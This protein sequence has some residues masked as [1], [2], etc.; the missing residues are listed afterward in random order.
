MAA[1]H[2]AVAD[3]PIPATEILDTL[4]GGVVVV[5]AADLRVRFANAAAEDMVGLS[6][7]RL[8]DRPLTEVAEFGEQ[9]LASAAK[10]LADGAAFTARQV[11]LQS[12]A[13]SAPLSVDIT[14]TPWAAAPASKRGVLELVPVDRH[15]RIARE[16]GLRDQEV[17]NRRL[18]R[19]LAHEIRNPLAGLR[20]A[21]QL[22]A[23]AGDAAERGEYT[24]MIV[25]EA[26]RLRAL[27][28]RMG[29]PDRPPAFEPVNIHQLT[30]HLL[31]LLRGEAGAGIT[32]RTHY[33]PSLPEVAGDRDQLLQALLNLGRNALQAVGEA[34]AIHVRTSARRRFTIAGIQHRVVACIEVADDG[35]G[36][37]AELRESLFQPLV[38]GRAE[39][40]GLGLSLAQSLARRH[41]GLIECESEPG[42]TVFR[43]LLPLEGPREAHAAAGWTQ[44]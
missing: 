38:S 30:E 28:D 3:E 18:L 25:R 12:R 17:S 4:T 13:M 44:P 29:G 5:E 7:Q 34:G 31:R 32:L 8:L 42:A 16:E 33:D 40:S 43:L 19:G 24:D 2:D 9:G 35:P 15:L 10:A 23:G 41:G 39:G 20:G 14:V 6:R 22:L 26:D 36:I 11:S 1:M 27:V 21:A 37:P